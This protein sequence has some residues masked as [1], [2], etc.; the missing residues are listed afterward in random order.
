MSPQTPVTSFGLAAFDGLKEAQEKLDFG[1][2]IAR[3]IASELNAMGFAD[4][5]LSKGGQTGAEAVS[6]AH[7]FEIHWQKQGAGTMKV[8]ERG[9][10][11]LQTSLGI[12]CVDVDINT[13]ADGTKSG[14]ISIVRSLGLEPERITFNPDNTGD[15]KFAVAKAA[16]R[17][18]TDVREKGITHDMVAQV[19]ATNTAAE[20]TARALSQ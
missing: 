4:Y 6:R 7:F 3:Q 20:R 9:V 12:S 10:R 19:S 2:P 13:N 15:V 16:V 18:M 5:G 17:I 11:D 14:E 8:D 1:A